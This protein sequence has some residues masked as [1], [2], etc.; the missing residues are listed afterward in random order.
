MPHQTNLNK[1]LKPVVYGKN[2][3]TNHLLLKNNS[4]IKENEIQPSNIVYKFTFQQRNCEVLYSNN[5][6]MTTTKLNGNT[7]EPH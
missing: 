6:F 7:K 3:K 4:S 2:K 1:K 5:I